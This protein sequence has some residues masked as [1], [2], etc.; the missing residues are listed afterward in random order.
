ML[1]PLYGLVESVSTLDNP[2]PHNRLVALYAD[3]AGKQ[4][5]E[6]AA[7]PTRFIFNEPPAG[8]F[9][10]VNKKF[11][12]AHAPITTQFGVPTIHGILLFQDNAHL[13][14]GVD[15]TLSGRT[16]TLRSAPHDWS[17]LT[18]YYQTRD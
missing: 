8:T 18:A 9:N 2:I 1:I 3:S 5:I 6:F 12:L 4:P 16:I 11:T 14:E 15:Y 7:S 17:N 13:Y 10:S